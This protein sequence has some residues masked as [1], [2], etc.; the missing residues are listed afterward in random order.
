MAILRPYLMPTAG[1]PQ[2]ISLAKQGSG[3][4]S[5]MSNG[6]F[7]DPNNPAQRRQYLQQQQ[8]S[9]PVDNSITTYAQD[10][11]AQSPMSGNYI[12]EQLARYNSRTPP[13]ELNP[14]SRVKQADMSQVQ[15]DNFKD[16][17]TQLGFINQQGQEMLGA[18]QGKAAYK[19]AEEAKRI[20][21]MTPPAPNIPQLQAD[22]SSA[23]TSG[24]GNAYGN[25]VPSNP[26]QNFRFAQQIAPRYGW[27][28]NEMSAWYTLGMKES[29]W[30]SD[31]QNPTSTAFGIGQFLDT[32]WGGYGIPKTRDAGQQVEAM[33]RYI[34]ARYGSPSAALAFHYG[35]NWY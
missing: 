31:A 15:P 7:Y 21:A 35:H 29:G 10:P 20:A 28:P 22:G 26:Q 32:T 18:E 14:G 17:Y 30:R 27:G 33:A 4:G 6:D 5:N 9:N 19:Q 34:K 23:P 24:G 2:P 12:Q 16:Y 13:P 11:L 8:T 25:G 3:Y 1:M